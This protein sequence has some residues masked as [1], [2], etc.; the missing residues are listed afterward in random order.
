NRWCFSSS[1]RGKDVLMEGSDFNISAFERN[2][3]DLW[4][5]ESM[6]EVAAE[7]IF[8]TLIVILILC[9]LGNSAICIIVSRHYQL[10]TVTN[11]YFVNMA[12]NQL[13]FALFSIPPYLRISSSSIT[14]G[15]QWLC[16][17]IGF[18]FEFFA[19]L[20]SLAL[21]L[22]TIER[23]YVISNSGRK[24]ISAKTTSKMIFAAS[25]SALTFA[26][27]WLSLDGSSTR[28]SFPSSDI[29]YSLNCFPLLGAHR[30]E[31]LK[32][33]NI[34]YVLM[35]FLLP[36]AL[37]AVL[38]VKMARPLWSGSHGVRPLGIG[39]TNTIRFFAEIKTTRT[40][41]LISVLHLC[42]WLP[43]CITSLYLSSQLRENDLYSFSSTTKVVS[44]C[45]A[46]ASS[47]INPLMYALRNPRFSIIFR[48]NRRSREKESSF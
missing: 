7:A 29:G 12:V 3:T 43:L 27:L 32:I 19:A 30:T 11:A 39:N 4:P 13:L 17:F 10:H 6:S 36:M 28:C 15:E 34:I 1:F 9:I 20:S 22:L 25:V 14:E 45:L 47:C 33:L 37:M 40:L 42:C 21:T 18:S 31:A 23:Y 2:K 48:P 46:F 16:V 8:T 5:C 44:I 26:V 38:F 41:F 24:K 35:C